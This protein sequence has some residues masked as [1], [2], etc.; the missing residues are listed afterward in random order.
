MRY[1]PPGIIRRAG[2]ALSALSSAMYVVSF[3]A[4]FAVPREKV[5]IFIKTPLS[6]R[7]VKRKGAAEPQSYYGLCRAFAPALTRE[8]FVSIFEGG[9]IFV[10]K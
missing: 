2:R 5:S 3:T 9:G 7:R 4:G 1:P 6:E 10:R 8:T